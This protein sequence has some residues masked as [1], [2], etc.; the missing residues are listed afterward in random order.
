MDIVER[1]FGGADG[2]ARVHEGFL[3]MP[4]RGP[5]RG[6]VG[7]LVLS[8]SSGRIEDE[9]CRILAREGMT[10]LSIRWFGGPGQPPGICEVPL[11][12]FGSAIEVL[13]AGGARRIGVLGVSKGAE[14]ALHLAVLLSG[15]DAVVALSPTSTTW[16]NVGPGRDGRN[17]PCR[18]SWSWR[19]EPL[20]FVPYDD[21]WAPV[22]TPPTGAPVAVRDWYE[23]SRRTFADRVDAAAIAVERSA[24]E[25]VLVAGGDDAMWPSLPW[26]EEL[27]ARR[28]AAG[29]PVRV[30][31]SPD[32]GH[33][34]RLPGEGPAAASAH[35]LYGGTPTADAALGTAAWPCILDALRGAHRGGV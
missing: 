28:R 35:F 22:P 1:T 18:S 11:E 17:R 24:A 34:P 10:A 7:V 9:R 31:S 5:V 8:G 27:A 15:V 14:A 13:R 33:R 30:I 25:L 4:A 29:R 6:G 21:S 16:A 32:A 23:R 26:A 3:A 12:T 20:P 19:G 2:D